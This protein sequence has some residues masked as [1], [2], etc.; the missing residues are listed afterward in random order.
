[1]LVTVTVNETVSFG[2]TVLGSAVM[3]TATS[4]DC[5][6]ATGAVSLL[7]SGLVSVF[8]IPVRVAVASPPCVPAVACKVKVTVPPSASAPIDQVPVLEL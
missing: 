7:L 5:A 8:S 1:M 3:V 2:I 6:T 4:V